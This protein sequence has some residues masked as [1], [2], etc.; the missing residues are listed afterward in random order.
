M[1][2]ITRALLFLKL[3]RGFACTCTYIVCHKKTPDVCGQHELFSLSFNLKR[4]S[5]FEFPR[6]SLSTDKSVD[7]ILFSDASKRA[8]GWVAY[9]LQN[10]Q[11]NYLLSKVKIF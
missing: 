8:Y 2:D 11:T 7:L 1:R 10:G 6:Y 5:T 3:D 4:T 9:T